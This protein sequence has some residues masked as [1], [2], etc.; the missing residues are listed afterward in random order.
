MTETMQGCL[1][2]TVT[3]LQPGEGTL[4]LGLALSKL[5]PPSLPDLLGQSISKRQ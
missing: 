5:P 3:L 1:D 4:S 2:I